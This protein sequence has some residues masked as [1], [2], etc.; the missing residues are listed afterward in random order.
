MIRKPEMCKVHGRNTRTDTAL[1]CDI[2]SRKQSS[3]VQE[4]SD[5]KYIIADDES[6]Q[7][8]MQNHGDG[9]SRSNMTTET[10]VIPVPSTGAIQSSQ[11]VVSVNIDKK[12]M[13]PCFLTHLFQ[14][15]YREALS[16]P[17]TFEIKITQLPLGYKDDFSSSLILHNEMV[18]SSKTNL[19]KVSVNIVTIAHTDLDISADVQSVFANGLQECYQDHRTST[20]QDLVRLG[21][22]AVCKVLST[23]GCPKPHYTKLNAPRYSTALLGAMCGWKTSAFV[24]SEAQKDVTKK[25]I[26]AQESAWTSDHA[27]EKDSVGFSGYLKS[28]PISCGICLAD[29]N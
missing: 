8:W 29:L 25:D 26:I 1:Q 15:N 19:E 11:T 17:R 5:R 6:V 16:I 13:E 22:D 20:V 12:E 3:A 2:I 23:V 27:V 4:S 10:H 18:L 21:T 14:E 9:K 7:Q 24:T 28:S